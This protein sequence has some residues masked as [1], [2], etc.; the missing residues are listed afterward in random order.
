MDDR[1]D[2]YASE[3]PPGNGLHEDIQAFIRHY[4]TQVDT[5]GRHV[6]YSECWAEDGVLVVPTGAEFHGREG[7][8]RQ[9]SRYRLSTL[10]LQKR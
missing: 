2:P 9:S 8:N 4:Y 5:Q 10:T 6:E 3:Y 7:T 1:D